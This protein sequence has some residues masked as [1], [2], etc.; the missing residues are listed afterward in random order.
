[1]PSIKKVLL[2][3]ATG[4]TGSQ[5][6]REL[7]ADNNFAQ[8]EAWVRKPLDISH[9]KLKCVITDFSKISHIQSTTATHIFC[10][11]GTTI[12]K[13]GS[14]EAFREIDCGYV[15][16]LAKLAERSHA[17]KFI[18]ISSLGA[19]ADSGNFYLHVKGEME[20]AVKNCSIPSI[21]ILRPSILLG[22]RQE[23]RIGEV[24]GKG[25]F[26][27]F[28]FL[29]VGKLKKYR[30]IESATVARAMLTLAKEQ[31]EGVY[32]IESDHIHKWQAIKK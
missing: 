5:C 11:L 18:V 29:L 19:S 28:N 27:T 16:E 7:I 26:R 9:P 8:I 24:I 12:R 15:V 13:A 14:Q 10:C 3:G 32:I 6:L 20:E 1:M 21:I 23:F 4:L 30:G 22:K 17:E 2:I 25:L 31:S